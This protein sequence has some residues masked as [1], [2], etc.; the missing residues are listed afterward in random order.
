MKVS[1]IYRKYKIMPNLQTHMLR[2]SSVASIICDNF[3]K[4]IDKNLIITAALL[5]DIGNMVRFKLEVFPEFLEPE[6]LKFWSKTQQEFIRKYGKNDYEATYKILRQIGIKPKA[7]SLIKSMEF[8]KAPVNAK[9]KNFEMKIC[10]YSDLRVAPF[11]I[12]SLEE[13]LR[14]VQNRFMRNKGV[15]DKEFKHLAESM[16]KIEKQ[17]FSTTKIRPS[18]ITEEQVNLLMDKFRDFEVIS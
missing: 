6:G 2:V 4:P 9:L 14:E 18:D 1:E 8:K 11:G 5:H 15:S 3:L 17:I 13:R 7:F 16:K 12:L 10:Q